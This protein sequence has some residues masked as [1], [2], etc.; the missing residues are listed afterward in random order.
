MLDPTMFHA[1]SHG[2]FARTTMTCNETQV[3]LTGVKLLLIVVD[4]LL[5]LDHAL[6]LRNQR[7]LIR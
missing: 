7:E 5:V 2:R 4:I 6:I 1:L 3:D